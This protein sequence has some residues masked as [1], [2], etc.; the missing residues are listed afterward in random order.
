MLP[1]GCRIG[2]ELPH[3]IALSLTCQPQVLVMG[4][5]LYFP[6]AANDNVHNQKEHEV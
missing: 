4:L 1:Q 2:L 6:S 5:H 3:N